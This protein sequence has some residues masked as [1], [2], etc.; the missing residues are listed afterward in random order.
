MYRPSTSICLVRNLISGHGSH[1]GNCKT[2]LGDVAVPWVCASSDFKQV[3]ELVGKMDSKQGSGHISLKNLTRQ[4]KRVGYCNLKFEHWFKRSYYYQQYEVSTLKFAGRRRRNVSSPVHM[5]AAP[6]RRHMWIILSFCWE[7]G[8][9]H[10]YY[11]HAS[12]HFR[13]ASD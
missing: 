8:M 9:L 4:I 10:A 2:H 12:N 5:R 11:V 13:G 7:P 1:V 3:V 6:I